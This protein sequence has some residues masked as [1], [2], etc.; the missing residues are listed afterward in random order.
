MILNGTFTVIMITLQVIGIAS[1]LLKYIAPLTKNKVDDR[2]QKVLDQ[3]LKRVSLDT[4]TKI[5]KIKIDDKN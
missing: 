3:I 2:V 4:N 1:I 5:L